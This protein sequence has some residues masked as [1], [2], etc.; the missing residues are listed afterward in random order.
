MNNFSDIIEFMIFHYL[1]GSKPNNALN[2]GPRLKNLRT[3]SDWGYIMCF[4]LFLRLLSNYTS[5]ACLAD[6]F[7]TIK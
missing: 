6:R 1:R 2:P 7:Y 3:A 5:L 4:Y